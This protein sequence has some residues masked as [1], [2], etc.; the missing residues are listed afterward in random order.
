M[1]WALKNPLRY[2]REVAALEALAVSTEGLRIGPIAPN[3]KGQLAAEI[4]LEVRD[5]LFEGSLTYPQSFPNVPPIV[6]PREKEHWSGHQYGGGGEFCLEWGPD[7]WGP[8]L[9]GADM[10]GSAVK[11]LR[12]EGG[13][14]GT[15]AADV[16]TRHSTTIGQQARHENMRL[17]CTPLLE[18]ALGEL[19][20]D[21]EGTYAAR[22]GGRL[23][24]LFVTGMTADASGLEWADVSIPLPFVEASVALKGRVLRVE[25]LPDLEGSASD[26]RTRLL[27]APAPE[28]A[29]DEV[30]LC[31]DPRGRIAAVYLYHEQETAHPLLV[32]RPGSQGRRL[33]ADPEGLSAKRVGIVGCGSLGSKVAASLARSGVR[34]FLLIDDDLLLGENIV[35]H[36]LDWND[37]GL[38]KVD[39]VQGRLRRIAPDIDIGIRRHRLGGQEASGAL[40]SVVDDLART[41]LIIEATADARAF[42]YASAAAAKVPM[43]WA[44]VFG[45]GYGGMIARAR[46]GLDPAPQKARALIETWCA[47]RDRP[48]PVSG[49]RY[50]GL[51]RDE[52]MVAD[53]AAVG[54]IASHATAMALD[55][56]AGLT[57]SRFPRS[58]YMIGL[59]NEWIFEA[60]F[61]TWPIDLG[62][63]AP[64][65][66]EVDY[67]SPEVLEALHHLV[68]VVENAKA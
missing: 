41:D 25:N 3:G 42:N 9:T 54:V 33:E 23:W 22:Y 30:V 2:A 44:E 55:I 16:D 68:D 18:T 65:V 61:D 60:P 13:L 19:E 24:R 58:A 36:D 62:E 8:E 37:V 21:A 5:R 51:V 15:P 40:D 45:G 63:A 11:L 6:A 67:S 34:R 49:T 48:P 28:G 43:I 4:E 38:H 14:P 52:P 29:E 10:V 32:I 64:A 20:S 12:T 39:S 56:L 26:V 7:N 66:S 47:A 27:G 17:I 31:V 35:R 53:D 1:I 46:P 57:P 50:D 59:A